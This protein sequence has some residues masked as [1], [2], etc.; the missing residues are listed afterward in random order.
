[1]SRKLS[2]VILAAGQGT[3][4]KSDRPKVLHSIGGKPM[5]VH[6]IERA[7]EQQPTAVYVV[8]GHGGE[9][10][11]SALSGLP[12][13][14]ILQDQQLG[15]GHAVD[16]AMSH[17]DD[18]QTVLVLYGDVP[19]IGSATLSRLI[20]A[21]DAGALGLLTAV[22]PDPTGYGR[23]VRDAAG[24]V[25]AIVEQKDASPEQLSIAEI[26]TGMM[27]A[28]AGQ[29]KDWLRRIDNDNAQGEYY[30][31]DVIELAAASGVTVNAIS[32]TDL[33]EIEGVNN[34]L[35]LATLEREYQRRQAEAL[36]LDGLILRDPVRFDL[37]GSLQIGRD[38]E[39]DVNV[40]MEGEISLG[41]RCY[42]GPNCQLKNVSLGS[43][44]RIEANSVL[45]DAEVGDHS[46]IGP[47]ARLRPG[48]QLAAKVKV[49]NFV[50]I[51]KAHIGTGSKVNHLSYV[52]DT[53]MGKNVN[54]G[55]GAITCNY[56]GANK[57]L[58]EIGDDVFIGSDS[59]L[60]APVKIGAG[61][62][63]GAGS[64]ITRDVPTNEL[65]LSRVA[66]KT[67]S[68]WQRPVKDK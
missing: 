38:V 52:G 45:E 13:E 66:Q 27:A 61:A 7:A 12:V 16:Q 11:Q 68:G 44:V 55:A 24:T 58:T 42:I 21:A 32:T 51:K 4:M 34:K 60:V 8:Y 6:V 1:M 64:T 26:N 62:T 49:G 43:D 14:W 46:V 65:T 37:R 67:I 41:D 29:L 48:S 22:L 33:A 59:Q 2:I 47:F 10:V 53:Q 20:A 54:V 56:D 39:V 28:S 9:Q 30:L 50:E 31:T 18:G 23:I 57:H 19:L 40:V 36:L 25:Q 3:R 63:I 35:Q 17:I 5:L 15:T